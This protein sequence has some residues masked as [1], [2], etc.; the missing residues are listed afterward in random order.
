MAEEKNKIVTDIVRTNT[1]IGQVIE[2]DIVPE[3]ERSYLE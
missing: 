2:T 1:N 3:M